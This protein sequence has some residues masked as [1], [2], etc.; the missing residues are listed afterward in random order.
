MKAKLL[1]IKTLFLILCL[2]STSALWAQEQ[3]F[4]TGVVVD[5][6]G[7]SLPGASAVIMKGKEMIKGTSTG[8]NGEF[9]I[10]FNFSGTGYELVVSYIGSKDK[11]IKLTKENLNTQ[12]D[13]QLL[14][15]D[16]MLEEVTIVEDGYA[17]LPRKDMVG[18]FTT[19]KAE[20]IM[21][22]AYQS[23]DQMLQGKVAGMSVVNTSAR[24]GASPKITIRGTATILGN[25][26]G[27]ASCRERVC[28]SV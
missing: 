24:V 14:P 5:E 16:A 25:K 13:I 22:P 9:R 4:V 28:L 10:G 18:A 12:L 2:T 27:R 21:M 7:E 23:I 6:N 20:D 15:D 17:R 8:I 3:N 19:V 1:V 11:I 26:I